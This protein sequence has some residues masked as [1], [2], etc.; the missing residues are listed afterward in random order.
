MKRSISIIAI[1]LLIGL[2]YLLLWPVPVEPVAWQSTPT[3]GYTGDFAAND[4]LQAL[5]FIDLAGESG[6]EDA[7]VGP[8]GAVYA[9][10]HSGKVLRLDIETGDVTEFA[11]PGG[12][13]LG[14]EFS[15]NGELYAANAL[16]GLTKFSADGTETILAD[17][18]GDGS[19]IGFADDLDIARNGTVYFSDA[20]TKFG[21]DAYAGT[22]AASMLD[23]IE[24][25]GHGRVLKFDPGTKQTTTIVD[26]LNFANGIALAA[27]ENYL[28]IAETGTYSVLK[29][30]LS[31]AQA[32]TTET[33]IANLPGFPDNINDNPN[34]TFW[35]GL[36]SPRSGPVDKMA[37]YPLLRKITMR[38]P[39]AVRPKPQR[40]GFAVRFDGDGN[41][42]ETLQ[43]PQGGYALVTGAV[44]TG[45]GRTIFTSLSEPRLGYLDTVK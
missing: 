14:L 11:T 43:D 17:E 21:V 1:I 19:P 37:P 32:G 26:G 39:E 20:S 27:D 44:D 2:G 38:L 24:H 36:V 29:H 25:G 10:T 12:R 22:L 15:T 28:L 5:Q 8:N 4:R 33:L 42:L 7:A 40:Y 18:A 34:G 41:I 31:G 16:R 35:V 9:S 3:N 30:W 23:L 45:D 13:V 6:P